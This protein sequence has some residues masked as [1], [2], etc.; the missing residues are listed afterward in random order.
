MCRFR[1]AE[2][3]WRNES[4]VTLRFDP[5][6]DS[7]TEIRKLHGIKE[8]FGGAMDAR[9]TPVEFFPKTAK[10]LSNFAG[11]EFAFYAGRPSW[12]PVRRSTTRRSSPNRA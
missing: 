12:W 10:T 5:K 8:D 9:H 2:A 4:E 1:S 6:G 11:Y 3:V 7:H